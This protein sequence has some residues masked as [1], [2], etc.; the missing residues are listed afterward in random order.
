MQVEALTYV[1]RARTMVEDLKALG[2]AAYILA[3]P[4]E[5]PSDPYRVRVG[6]YPTRAAAMRTATR[7]EAHLGVKLWVTTASR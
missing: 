2:F 1:T 5:S 7:L 4:S 6:Q 3:P